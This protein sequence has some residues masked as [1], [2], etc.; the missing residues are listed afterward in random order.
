MKTKKRQGA[1][2]WRKTT[3]ERKRGSERQRLI[4]TE[5]GE[6]RKDRRATGA[7]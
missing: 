7:R 5:G 6:S 2:K 4:K 1:E 3:S